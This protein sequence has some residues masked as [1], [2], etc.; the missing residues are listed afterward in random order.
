MQVGVG[1][2]QLVS[3]Y[4]LEYKCEIKLFFVQTLENYSYGKHISMNFQT[5]TFTV[6]MS[7]VSL[8]S[9]L[10]EHTFLCHFQAPLFQDFMLVG[11][12]I[13]K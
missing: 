4:Q 13:S 9:H 10:E 6:W 8:I 2:R 11:F 7:D 1:P 5:K 3:L 12:S